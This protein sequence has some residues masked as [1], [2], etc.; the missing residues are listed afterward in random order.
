MGFSAIKN[1]GLRSA[2]TRRAS[3]HI[4]RS[5]SAPFCFPAWL[6]G[7]QGT[8]AQIRSTCQSPSLP[9]GNVRTSPQRVT[10]GQCFASTRPA[11]SSIST[12]HLQTIPA[13]SSPRSKPPIPAKSDPNVSGFRSIARMYAHRQIGLSLFPMGKTRSSLKSAMS[14]IRELRTRLSRF[15]KSES[16]SLFAVA[17]FVTFHSKKTRLAATDHTKETTLSV[18]FPLRSGR[19][20][21]S[22]RSI[23]SRSV[24]KKI[25]FPY[26]F[27]SGDT[28]H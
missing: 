27:H 25:R 22:S 6:T 13:R 18:L 16:L 24:S 3:P 9:G 23:R 11:Y 12:C 2:T 10:L 14:A 20:I 1:L 26:S 7:W 4:H 19:Y 21:P 8:P 15:A 5:S 17:S 28:V